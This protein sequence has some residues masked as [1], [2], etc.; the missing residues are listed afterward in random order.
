[1]TPNGYALADSWEGAPS[2]GD[3]GWS[4]DHANPQEFPTAA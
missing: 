2:D 3:V 1:M 4:P